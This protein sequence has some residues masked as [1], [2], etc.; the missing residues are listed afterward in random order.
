MPLTK[1]P[2]KAEVVTLTLKTT[3]LTVA[4]QQMLIK[5]ECIINAKELT[6]N[7]FASTFITMCIFGQT[8]H[9]TRK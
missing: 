3:A 2:K 5:K 1:L 9:Y 6:E 7:F 8:V 4:P